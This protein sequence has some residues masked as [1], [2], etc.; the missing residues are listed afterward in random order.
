MIFR[1]ERWRWDGGERVRPG[2][3]RAREERGLEDKR[4]RRR[5]LIVLFVRAVLAEVRNISQ[6]WQN[7]GE[8]WR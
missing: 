1:W 3:L 7:T 5:V 6:R 4:R 8:V 2:S